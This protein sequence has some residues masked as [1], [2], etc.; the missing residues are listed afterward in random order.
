VEL[1]ALE[2][3]LA[4]H[5][6]AITAQHQPNDGAAKCIA[7]G[8]SVF[9]AL[10]HHAANDVAASDS[11]GRARPC[12]GVATVLAVNAANDQALVSFTAPRTEAMRAG[13]ESSI[14]VPL[15]GVRL[16]GAAVPGPWLEGTI[17]LARCPDDGLF[18]LACVLRC[19]DA[20]DDQSG[21]AD[22]NGSCRCSV[23]YLEGP[24]MVA[25]VDPYRG[26]LAAAP[27]DEAAAWVHRN[28]ASAA[29]NVESDT[30]DTS[31]SD[32]ASEMESEIVATTNAGS[33]VENSDPVVTRL[34]ERGRMLDDGY[35]FAHWEQYTRGIGS[36]LL[37][38]MGFKPVCGHGW[39][40]DC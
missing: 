1:Q 20:D 19:D 9:V 8:D 32:D 24:G 28:Q 35:Q 22:G 23:Q 6:A 13:A 10:D 14:A 37:A 18:H 4:D 17:C 27:P 36:K 16:A 21:S 2:S 31:D 33:S 7:V 5:D 15:S 26:D 12:A 40:A 30:D 11:D 3:A 34:A 25:V 29:D 39:R 38:R